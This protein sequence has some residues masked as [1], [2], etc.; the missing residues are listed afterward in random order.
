MKKKN[1][2]VIN[3]LREMDLLCRDMQIMANNM[4]KIDNEKFKKHG[5]ELNGAS[6]IMK[7]W[8]DGIKKE[9]GIIGRMNI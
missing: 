3:I 4:V 2:E 9:Y 6:Q 1:W 8:I 7:E 5:K